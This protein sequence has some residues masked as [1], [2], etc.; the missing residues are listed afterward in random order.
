MTP[1]ETKKKWCINWWQSC[2]GKHK[3]YKTVPR[4]LRPLWIQPDYRQKHF[5]HQFHKKGVL[6]VPKMCFN[7]LFLECLQYY[8][9]RSHFQHYDIFFSELHW[10]DRSSKTVFQQRRKCFLCLWNWAVSLS[11]KRTISSFIEWSPVINCQIYRSSFIKYIV[12]SCILTRT[13]V[14]RCCSKGR[15]LL[16][17][18]TLYFNSSK[19]RT[20]EL[21]FII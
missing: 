13:S 8:V 20:V 14:L 9:S 16:F 12:F 19:S 21:Y 5:C 3:Q 1:D 18:C 2:E 10:Q 7:T 11:Y 15:P 17:S 4:Q 6:K